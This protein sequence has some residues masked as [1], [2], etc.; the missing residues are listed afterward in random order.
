M[1]RQKTFW[2][3]EVFFHSKGLLARSISLIVATVSTLDYYLWKRKLK[4]ESEKRPNFDT[5]NKTMTIYL[6]H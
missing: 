4:Q 3:S 6:F 1:Q 2:R 5:E